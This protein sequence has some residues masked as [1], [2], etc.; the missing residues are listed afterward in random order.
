MASGGEQ[1]EVLKT[2][3]KRGEN[4]NCRHGIKDPRLAVFGNKEC[5]PSQN[6]RRSSRT[7]IETIVL[8]GGIGEGWEEA[9]PQTSYTNKEDQMGD[10]AEMEESIVSRWPH[11]GGEKRENGVQKRK[12]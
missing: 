3:G 1:R 2:E 9:G 6:S 4:G 11:S 10:V 8:W 12:G 5:S 7:G